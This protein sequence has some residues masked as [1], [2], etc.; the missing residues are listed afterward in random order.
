LRDPR[1]GVG[2]RLKSAT[3]IA[4]EH[5]CRTESQKS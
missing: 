3:E 1:F 5:F 2:Y 4:G